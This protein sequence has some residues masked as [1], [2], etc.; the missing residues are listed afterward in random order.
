MMRKLLLF[1]V[2]T[3][4]AL[5]SLAASQEFEATVNIAKTIAKS[6]KFESYTRAKNFDPENVFKNYTNNPSQIKYYNGVSSDDVQ[7]MKDDAAQSKMS[8]A[9]SDI[10]KSINQHP[11]YVIKPS[12][13]DIQHSQLL[14][15]EAD[16]IIHGITS[17]YIDC[18][19]KQACITQYQKNQCEEAQQAIF[20]TCTKKLNID[21]TSN[22]TVTH[23]PLTAHLAVKEHN[24]AGI[25]VNSVN[26]QI[27]FIGPHDASFK[28][29]GRLPAN[30]D[31]STLQGSIVSRKGNAKLDSINFPSCANGLW[32]DFH[33]SGG[34]TLDL[35]IDIASKVVTSDIKDN[36]VDHCSG[37]ATDTTCKLQSQQ[38]DIPN[39]TQIIQGIPVTRECWQQSFNYLCRG[40]SGEGTCKPLQSKGCEQ[41]GSECKEKTNNQCTLY[42]QT[43]RCPVQSC[44]PTTDV[45]CGNGQEYCLEGDCTDHSYQGSKDFAKAA[46]A[47]ATV[48]D[49]AKQL[50][51]SSMAIFTGHPTE[52]SEKPIGYS[53]CCTETGW[54]Q[55]VGLDHC[56]EAA[57]KLHVDRENKLAIKVGRY[58]SGPDPFPC[59]EHSQVF[60]VFSSKLAK[61]IQ[62]QGRGRQLHINFGRAKEPNCRGITADELQAVDLSKINFK[63]FMTDLNTNIKNHDLKQI[64]EKIQQQVQQANQTGKSNG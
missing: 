11:R 64:Q 36:W 35:Q 61:I 1:F 13:P 32:L 56:P 23:Y 52:C 40:G 39:S 15:K 37:L 7:Q 26:G 54:G 9:G 12:D 45:I 53:N 18:K 58:C 63:D 60:C 31:C 48:D 21:I 27:S 49:A 19:P 43:Y 24:Y 42:R 62:E 10:S 29:A 34:H 28:L 38:C 14:Q 20:Q 3:F 55:D 46:S 30:I 25:S 57:K 4:I 8:E 50:D 59:I 16:N 17:Q 6:K 2:I 47:L 5:K 33:I 22:E 51:Q 44:S 41:V